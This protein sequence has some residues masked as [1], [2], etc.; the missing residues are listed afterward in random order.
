MAEQK[1]A[2]GA[3][4]VMS[5]WVHSDPMLHKPEDGPQPIDQHDQRIA[6]NRQQNRA[7]NNKAPSGDRYL[8]GSVGPQGMAGGNTNTNFVPSMQTTEELATR[9][10]FNEHRTGPDGNP[11][12]DRG[13]TFVGGLARAQDSSVND[14]V[15]AQGPMAMPPMGEIKPMP[16]NSMGEAKRFT[17]DDVVNMLHMYHVPMSNDTINAMADPDGTIHPDRIKSL[18]EYVK[19]VAQGLFP[20]LAPHIKAGIPTAYL[21]DPYRQVA[22]MLIGEHVEPD[23]IGDPKWGMALTG[24]QDKDGRRIPM[25]LDEWKQHMMRSRD[26]GYQH[27]DAAREHAQKVAAAIHEAFGGEQ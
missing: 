3:Y 2:Q 25:G 14:A 5:D 12:P 18:E 22:K 10:L 13:N 1:G 19:N 21:V 8:E 23:F 20:T 26:Y 9:N 7:R 11:L 17:P 4:G 24:G 6:D 15:G 16:D 27:T